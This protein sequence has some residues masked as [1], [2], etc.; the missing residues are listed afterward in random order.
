MKLSI[1]IPCYNEEKDIA[2]NV[3][4][5]LK[6]LHDNKIKAEVFSDIFLFVIARNND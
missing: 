5:V 1:I 4:I 6:Y 3:D 2:K